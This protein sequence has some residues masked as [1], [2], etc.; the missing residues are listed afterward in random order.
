MALIS[1]RSIRS[2]QLIT[3]FEFTW[4]TVRNS[5]YDEVFVKSRSIVAIALNEV[6]QKNARYATS[7]VLI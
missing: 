4:F 2:L 6:Y 7:S 1:E 5:P 3:L